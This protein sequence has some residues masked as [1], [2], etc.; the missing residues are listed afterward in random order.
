MNDAARRALAEFGRFAE[1][2]WSVVEPIPMIPS[3]H[4]GVV[5]DALQDVG[6]GRVQRLA[7]CIPPRHS[8]SLLASVLWPAWLHARDPRVKILTASHTMQLS[9]RFSRMHR[10][11]IRHPIFRAAYRRCALKPGRETVDA[12]ET[13]KGGG[14][15]SN[16]VGS[17][18][19]GSGGEVLLIDDPHDLGDLD[20][21]RAREKVSRWYRESWLSRRNADTAAEVI[22]MQRSASD[23]LVGEVSEFG[24]RVLAIPAV[25]TTDPPPTDVE[26]TDAREPG[27]VLTP[28]RLSAEYFA[29][30]RERMGRHYAAVYQQDPRPQGDGLFDRQWFAEPPADWEEK[31]VRRLRYWD[32]AATKPKASDAGHDP[33]WTVGAKVARLSGDPPRYVIENVIRMRDTPMRTEARQVAAAN[34]DGRD[35]VISE[36]QEPGASGV[37]AMSRRMTVLRGFAFWPD[38]KARAKEERWNAFSVQA[39]AGNVYALRA[40][41]N[42]ALWDELEALPAAR[43]DDQADAVSGALAMLNLRRRR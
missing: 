32:K 2:F 23:D 3:W 28:H 21:G 33:D 5:C 17:H 15:Y 16:S 6:E 10:E 25:A 39:E 20:N 27:E 41:W 29:G 26:F 36:E 13:T 9:R 1:A 19:T 7:V 40:G 43:H 8:K 14:R 24:F 37:E 11:I 31:V 12:W 22:I 42:D 30:E 34:A 18:V 38:R 4:M 35:V